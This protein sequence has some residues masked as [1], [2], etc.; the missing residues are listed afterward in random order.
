[1][2]SDENDDER[3]GYGKPPKHTRFK[4][5]KS[6]N[7]R[8]RARAE[9]FVDWDN[10]VQKYM[11]ESI[12]VTIKG[13]KTKLPVVDA[14]MKAAISRAL[15]GCPK[16]LKVLLDASGGLRA[17]VAEQKRKKGQADEEFLKEMR[18]RADRYRPG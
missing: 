3:V 12:T 9:E 16:N 4:P 14:L 15:G 8:G 7:P 1:M 18:T 11:L 6:G 10:P 13:K 2:T 17:L 5:G